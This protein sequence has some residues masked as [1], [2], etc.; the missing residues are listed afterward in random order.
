MNDETRHYFQVLL[1][2][3]LALAAIEGAVLISEHGAEALRG[4]EILQ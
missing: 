2:H 4:A 1:L 3:L